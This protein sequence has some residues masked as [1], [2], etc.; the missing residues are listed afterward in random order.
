MYNNIMTISVCNDCVW[1][2]LVLWNV[3]WLARAESMSNLIKDYIRIFIV[4]FITIILF[5]WVHIY[6]VNNYYNTYTYIILYNVSLERCSTI[7]VKF[8]SMNAG[9]SK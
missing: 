1:I 5:E 7:L 8:F 2:S 3:Q 6:N 4:L 9:K